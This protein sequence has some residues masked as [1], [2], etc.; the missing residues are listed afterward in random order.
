MRSVCSAQREVEFRRLV[1]KLPVLGKANSVCKIVKM[2]VFCLFVKLGTHHATFV[3]TTIVVCGDDGRRSSNDP[4]TPCD[5]RRMTA[6]TTRRQLA[7]H[8]TTATTVEADSEPGGYFLYQEDEE[9]E[10]ETLFNYITLVIG[11]TF[12]YNFN[13]V[14]F[15]I[16]GILNEDNCVNN[17]TNSIRSCFLASYF[18]I[19]Q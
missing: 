9:E 5:D 8:T 17:N 14:H 1:N 7:T 3:G 18:H 4:H 2:C 10:D 12:S 11:P 19:Q 15:V 13:I 16:V 6:H